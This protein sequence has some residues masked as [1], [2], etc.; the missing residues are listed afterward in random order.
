MDNVI[1]VL[2]VSLNNSE[3]TGTSYLNYCDEIYSLWTHLFIGNDPGRMEFLDRWDSRSQ[4]FEFGNDLYP[5]KTKDMK[6][7]S[8]EQSYGVDMKL[9]MEYVRKY[10][11][12]PHLIVDPNRD[13]G[14]PYGNQTAVTGTVAQVV[15]GFADIAVGKELI[16]Q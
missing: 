5:D 16:Q 7:D 14:L 2:V 10:N 8:L 9:L 11:L 4:S 3:C 15:N 1:D 12:T 13:W 6:G